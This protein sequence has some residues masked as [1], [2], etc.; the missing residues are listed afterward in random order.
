MEYTNPIFDSDSDP[1]NI[2]NNENI[3]ECQ[4]KIKQLEMQLEHH[5]NLSTQLQTI[6]IVDTCKRK[7]TT[8]ETTVKKREFI[9]E[10][11]TNNKYLKDLINGVGIKELKPREVPKSLMQAYLDFRY[12]SSRPE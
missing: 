2:D 9:K 7:Y 1:S 10:N 6:A 8:K 11:M 5:K 4:R 12:K 3:S